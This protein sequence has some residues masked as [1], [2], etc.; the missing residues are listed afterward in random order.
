MSYRLYSSLAGGWAFLATVIDC[1][2]RKVIGW[3][4]DDNH[5]TL[6]VTAVIEMKARNVDPPSDA[7]FYSDRGNN[8]GSA[9]FAAVR[10]GPGIRQ[11]AGRT[12]FCFGNASRN[13]SMLCLKSTGF[14]ERHIRRYGKP[15]RTLLGTSGSAIIGFLVIPRSGIGLRKKFMAST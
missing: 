4:V 14:T 8:Y 6:L 5:W 13:R 10:E 11:S 1:A 9:E 3:A 15:G 7:A 12:G 2:T